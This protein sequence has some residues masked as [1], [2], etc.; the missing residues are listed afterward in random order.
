MRTLNEW[1]A[2]LIGTLRRRRR[3]E[4]L[5]E[6]LRLHLEM[7]ADAGERRGQSS[8]QARRSAHIEFGGPAQAMEQLRDQRGL[9]AI[10]AL[11]SD[12]RFGWRHIR[13]SPRTSLAAIVSLALALG[14]TV[15]A[16][17]LLDAV[18]LR[19]MPVR[20]ANEL[21]AVSETVLNSDNRRDLREAF[22]YPTFVA[23]S[24]A[25]GADAKLMVLGFA[26]PVSIRFQP[27]DTAEQVNLQFVSGN[28][29]TEFGLVPAAG[30]LIAPHDDVTPGGHAVMVLGHRFWTDR[31]GGDPAIVGKPIYFG[32]QRYEIIGVAPKGFTGTEPGTITAVFVPAMM[33]AQAIGNPNWAWFRMWARPAGGASPEQIRQKLDARYRAD[34]AARN[35]TPPDGEIRLLPAGSGSS[36]LQRTFRQPLVLL[37][38]L[39]GLVLLMA[40][41]NVASTLAG[42]SIERRKEMALRISIGATR[43][44]L[45]RLVLAESAL[46]A[47]LAAGLGTLFAMWAAP[48]VASMI[49]TADRPVQLVLE[50]DWRTFLFGVM[51]TSAVTLAFGLV[52][53]LGA[54]SVRPAGALK[55]GRPR[56]HR[57]FASLLVT[58]Q[59]A[60]SFVLLFV[61]GLFVASFDRLSHRPLG[62]SHDGVV[63][64][65]VES[66]SEKSPEAWTTTLNDL[67]QTPGIQST[68]FAGWVPLSGN[69]WTGRAR[70]PGR[71]VEPGE[72]FFLDVSAGFF[73]T[74]GM[75]LIDGRDF[76]KGDVAPGIDARKKPVAGV[77]IV[78]ETFARAAFGGER[79][80]GR[81]VLLGRSPQDIPLEIV[82][83]VNDAAYLS[84]REAIKPT[85][86]LPVGSRDGGTI[87]VRSSVPLETLS[88]TLRQR[89]AELR[90]DLRV[91][92][93]QTQTLFVTRQMVRERVLSALSMFF[94]VVAVIL[95]G[96]G[97]YGVVNAAVVR[98]RRE[99][100]I[101][102]ALGAGRPHIIR[103]V[104]VR[105]AIAMCAGAGLG[106]VAGLALSRAVQNLLFEIRS[107]E[108]TILIGPGVALAVA[109]VLAAL[110]P[111]LRAIRTNPVH[112]LKE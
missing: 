50:L 42:Q 56:E 52:P 91:R 37:I 99:I 26:G 28:V 5:E 47:L 94:A 80:I 10:E 27:G 64:A 60:F 8:E 89:L 49:G 23:Y 95:A 75:R 43:G 48:L 13:K 107:T 68:A 34:H 44:R 112:V 6:E 104:I 54:S 19:P 93:I 32:T 98:Q 17:Q 78:N 69:R 41:V 87:V 71:A 100:G 79:A 88:G 4:D 92:R 7:A 72:S 110:P 67:G 70:I 111:V 66:R 83:I 51:L 82:G 31:F 33:N 16:F 39:A 106:L 1:I 77:G 103:G 40:C 29:F 9:P 46:L 57:R 108:P 36:A 45:I 86:Y 73:R 12:V 35:S 14:C 30:R 102:M 25:V 21:V 55:I 59:V 38:G 109:A 18:L 24:Q 22:D 85:V 81:R 105:F 62:F 15:A 20:A 76:Q 3:D 11:V 96:V 53:A 90:P 74:L 97:L 65:D 101:R 58:G 2:R 84:V 61:A 63:L